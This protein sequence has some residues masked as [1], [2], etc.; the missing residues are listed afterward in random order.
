MEDKKTNITGKEKKTNFISY[1]DDKD[2]K[3]EDWVDII[4]EDQN[5]V[6]FKY[7]DDV[8][9][10]PWHRVLKVKKKEIKE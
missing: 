1:L 5:T 6:T 8:I 10:I 4:S 2:N 7:R 3:R 9:T